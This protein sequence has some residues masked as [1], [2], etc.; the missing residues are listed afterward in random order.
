[1]ST[2][3]IKGGE[4]GEEEVSYFSVITEVFGCS[5]MP[6]RFYREAWRVCLS[7]AKMTLHENVIFSTIAP[8][9]TCFKDTRISHLSCEAASP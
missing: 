1:M 7:R 4:V 6:S 5:K 9:R 8:T 3:R 2:T